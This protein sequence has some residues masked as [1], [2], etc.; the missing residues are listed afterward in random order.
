MSDPKIEVRVTETDK[1]MQV[2][3]FSRRVDRIE[4]VLLQRLCR[5]SDRA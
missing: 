4:V 1:T 2:T 3:V 5:F